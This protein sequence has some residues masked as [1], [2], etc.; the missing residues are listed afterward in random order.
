[1]NTAV[2][3]L[4]SDGTDGPTDAAGGF[5]DGET[6]SQLK[7]EGL[8]VFRILEDNNAYPALKNRWPVDNRAHRHPR[9]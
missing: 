3:S 6:V 2:I 4:G 7:I 8:D 9:Q 1:M 5:V